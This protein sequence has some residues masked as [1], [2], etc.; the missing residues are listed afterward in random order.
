MNPSRQFSLVWDKDK[1]LD[2]WVVKTR[3]KDKK[4]NKKEKKREGKDIRP[5]F[6]KE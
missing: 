3:A 6:R 2:G 1:T 5:F 4:G